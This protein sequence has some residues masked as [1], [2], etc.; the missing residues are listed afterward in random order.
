MT[1]C[2]KSSLQIA[3]LLLDGP[4]DQLNKASFI[5]GDYWSAQRRG[6]PNVVGLLYS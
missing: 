1:D 5:H 2:P 4:V 6:R 3:E